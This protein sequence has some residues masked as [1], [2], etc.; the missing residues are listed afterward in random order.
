MRVVSRLVYCVLW[1]RFP[2][3]CGVCVILVP[4]IFVS[5]KTTTNP[6]DDDDD[7]DI[8]VQMVRMFGQIGVFL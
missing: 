3:V 5:T 7:D 2:G 6:D 1:L 4:M 8:R